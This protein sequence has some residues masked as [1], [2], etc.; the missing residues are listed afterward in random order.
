MKYSLKIPRKQTAF[1]FPEKLLEILRSNARRENKS[2]NNYVESILIQEVYKTPNEDTEE[3]IK[4]A[5]AG[6]SAG[7]LN[8]SSY[9]SFMESLNNIK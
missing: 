1:R 4:E 3:A 6:K 9:E 7:T 5:Q 2:L 8:V